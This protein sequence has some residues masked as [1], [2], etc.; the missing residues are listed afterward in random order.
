[1]VN[2]Q[3]L[4][5]KGNIFTNKIFVVVFCIIFIILTDLLYSPFNRYFLSKKY[6]KEALNIS[7]IKNKKLMVIGDPCVG[8]QNIMKVIQ[9]IS[10][11]VGHGDITI[12]LFGCSNCIHLDIN[13]I[14]KWKQ[15]ADDSFVIIETGTLSFSK[16]IEKILHEIKR[17]SGGDFFSAGGTRSYFWK[18]IGSHL[19]SNKYPNPLQSM[20]YPFNNKTDTNFKV[21][22][23]NTNTYNYYNWD[24][25]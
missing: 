14:D 24:K 19:Y 11:N 7:Q 1:M 5:Y 10:P 23:L 6:Y 9:S 17:I 12:D 20:M 13:D 21:F 8:N 15:F 25:I 18:Y 16:N 3:L 2:L 4:E 22:N